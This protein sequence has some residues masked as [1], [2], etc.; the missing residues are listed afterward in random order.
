MNRRMSSRTTLPKWLSRRTRRGLAWA[1][2]A[3]FALPWLVGE[4]IKTGLQPGISDAGASASMLVDFIA[5]G[6]V[7]FGLAMWVVVACGCWIVGVMKGPR[8]DGDA[9]P[10][11]EP[12]STT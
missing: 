4:W 7:L 3:V 6:S 5:I 1:L 11:D 2:L 8:V 12:R 10:P 9:F